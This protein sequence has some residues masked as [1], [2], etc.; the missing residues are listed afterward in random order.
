MQPAS[1]WEMRDRVTAVAW[2]RFVTGS[3][4]GDVGVRPEILLS[5]RRCRDEYKIDPGQSRAPS[6]DDYCDHSLKN[7]RVVTE[8][9]SVGRSLLDDVQAL[10]GLVAIADGA[11]RVLTAWGDRQALRHAEQS[12]LA[13]W[14]AWSDRATGTNGMGT[15]N[16]LREYSSGAASTGARACGTG[17]VRAPPSVIRSPARR[18]LFSMFHRGE[19]RSRTAS[20]PGCEEP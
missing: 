1:A 13:P 15:L 4:G 9:G 3:D 2:E 19:S 18:S 8:L 7:D 16:T 11:A 17:L 10:G 5:W 6:A 12:N 20:C 14:S